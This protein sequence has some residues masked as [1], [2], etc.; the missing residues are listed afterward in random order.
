MQNILSGGGSDAS[1]GAPVRIKPEGQ[2]IARKSMQGIMDKYLNQEENVGYQSARP[3]GRSVK[4]E[5]LE[6]AERNKGSMSDVMQGHPQGAPRGST[7]NPRVVK[8]EAQ[9]IAERNKGSIAG[10]LGC[11]SSETRQQHGRQGG[12]EAQSN[13]S[14]QQGSDMSAI[15]GG[16]SDMNVNGAARGPRVQSASAR[17][18]A[19]RNRG[20]VGDLFKMQ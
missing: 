8:S 5:A 7:N 19:E 15:M 16:V 1:D 3:Q 10:I 4:A 6:N 18:A 13:A 17:A 2:E 9:E 12:A 20:T 11:C 14:R